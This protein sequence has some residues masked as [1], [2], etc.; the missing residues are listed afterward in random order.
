MAW[1]GRMGR[2]KIG[3]SERYCMKQAINATIHCPGIK[4]R[5]RVNDFKAV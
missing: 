4:K 1:L 5:N 2:G 3:R